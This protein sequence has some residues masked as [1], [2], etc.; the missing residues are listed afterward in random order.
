MDSFTFDE[1]GR[2]AMSLADNPCI[3]PAFHFHLKESSQYMCSEQS[4]SQS[5]DLAISLVD[6]AF[7]L[8]K[9]F[10]FELFE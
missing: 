2:F 6:F 10:D 8:L 9:S 4:L 1:S 7:F 5:G 3:N